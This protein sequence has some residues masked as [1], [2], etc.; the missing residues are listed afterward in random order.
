MA[1]FSGKNVFV[2]IS[3]CG[4]QWNSEEADKAIKELWADRQTEAPRFVWE[5]SGDLNE[6]VH[7]VYTLDKSRG[8]GR[9]AF[10]DLL[11]LLETKR[12]NIQTFSRK[13]TYVHTLTGKKHRGKPH[14]WLFE[15]M[16]YCDLPDHEE[17][18]D[19]E[20][21]AKKKPTVVRVASNEKTALYNELK[22]K[23]D[24]WINEAGAEKT[25]TP[26]EAL[27][28]KVFAG[29]TRDELDDLLDDD[30]TPF[31]LRCQALDNYDKLCKQIAT[32]E[33]I[34]TRK[35]LRAAYKEKAAEYRPFQ[36]A[37]TEVLDTQDDRK[38]HV[39]VDDGNTG[40][41]RWCE[42]ENYRED[43]CLVQS[44]CT[45][46][47]AFVWDPKKHKRII[48]DVPRGKMEYL[49]TSAIEKLKNGQI[50]S[51]KYTPV[52]KQ[53]EFKPTIVILGNECIDRSTWTSDRLT[54]ST[55]SAAADY[56]IQFD[57]RVPMS[58]ASATTG[59]YQQGD[60]ESDYGS[61]D[62]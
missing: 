10:K 55:T 18:F 39:H 9:N 42:T 59:A 54:E 56:E 14:L 31:K 47:I 50:M 2:T 11:A 8:F 45:K 13:Q 25:Q 57:E 16:F 40:K 49:N 53:S 41:N 43:T 4:K 30:S 37:L 35:R 27:F 12:L 5:K 51:T 15:K 36:K 60:L 7:I 3:G 6:H 17:Y 21:L 28:T 23:Y 34:Q 38:I 33:V 62:N 22:R 48:V 19:A 24:A 44:A 26:K 58:R 46:D 29:M 20:K 1:K 52:F 32:M 61:V